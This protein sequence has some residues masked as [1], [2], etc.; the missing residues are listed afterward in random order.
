MLQACFSAQIIFK[1]IESLEVQEAIVKL[2]FDFNQRMVEILFLIICEFL[3]IRYSFFDRRS[4]YFSSLWCQVEF[5]SLIQFSKW[6][7]GP[8]AL[9]ILFYFTWLRAPIPITQIAI[10]TLLSF[11][12]SPLSSNIKNT[13]FNP[14][15]SWRHMVLP[16]PNYYVSRAF[17]M[18]FPSPQPSKRTSHFLSWSKNGWRWELLDQSKFS[19]SDNLEYP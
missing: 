13:S 17:P 7:N 14:H 8:C 11:N 9:L 2:A 15:F 12:L 5:R 3:K 18:R 1:R 6:R 10:F 4:Y 16:P 19:F